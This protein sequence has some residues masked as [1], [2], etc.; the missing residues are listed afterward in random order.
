[1]TL[2]SYKELNIKLGQESKDLEDQIRS[3]D[4]ERESFEKEKDEWRRDL[5]Q[6]RKEITEQNDRLTLLSQQL[7][8]EKVKATIIFK[9]QT[10]VV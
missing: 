5:E 8:G 4:M 1:M 6:A 7:S 10:D 3:L 9:Q 2:K